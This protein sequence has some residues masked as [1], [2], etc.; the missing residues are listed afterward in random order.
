[1]FSS[2]LGD[3]FVSGITQSYSS[4]FHRIRWKGGTRAREETS[5]LWLGL[6]LGE[7]DSPPAKYFAR[8]DVCCP[9]F[10]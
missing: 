8:A 5:T 1:V 4:D 6:E 10:F 2:A 9:A 3:L 7:T